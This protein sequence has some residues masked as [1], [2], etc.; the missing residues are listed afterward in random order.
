[1]ETTIDKAGR[2]V[3]PKAM[4]EAIGLV[5]GGRVDVRSEDG[6]IVIEAVPV[7]MRMESRG[8]VLVCVPT[9]ELPPLTAGDVRD[10]LES[11]RR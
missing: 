4:R 10:V 3:V 11:L 8:G 6:R 9:E 7:E 2:L 5:E 1:M